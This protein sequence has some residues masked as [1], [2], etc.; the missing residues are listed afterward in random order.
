MSETN[1]RESDLILGGQNPPPV[2]AAVL[3]GEDGRKQRLQHKK[4]QKFWQDFEYLNNI[5][6]RLAINFADRQVVDFEPN[7]DWV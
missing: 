3:G 4:A 7:P 2:N 5:P 1:P 6:H